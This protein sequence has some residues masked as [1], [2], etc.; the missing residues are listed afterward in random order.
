MRKKLLAPALIVALTGV[1]GL[2]A[3]GQQSEK[4]PLTVFAAASLHTSFKEIEKDVEK[5]H[6]DLDVVVSFDGS[7]NLVDQIAAGA[8]ADVLATADR[9]SMERAQE[10]LSVSASPFATNSLVLIT[11]P[12]NPHGISAV[13]QRLNEVK[14]VVCAE[15]VPCGAT[16]KKVLSQFEWQLRPVSEEQKV[17]DVVGKVRSGQADAGIVY[18]TDAGSFHAVDIPGAEQVRSDYMIANL[19]GDNPF[20]E[21]LLSDAGKAR[22]QEFGFGAP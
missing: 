8:P 4:R 19:T 7:Q 1:L 21:Y 11:A 6:P 18:R 17:T 20:T 2:T 14:T 12:D 3:C 22:L 5:L 16:T 9:R 13:D 15:Q 10:K